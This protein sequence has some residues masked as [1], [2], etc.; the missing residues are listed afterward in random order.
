MYSALKDTCKVLKDVSLISGGSSKGSLLF[1]A[2]SLMSTT[3]AKYLL[4]PPDKK[5]EPNWTNQLLWQTKKS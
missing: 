2:S 1:R 5:L 4:L 3:I